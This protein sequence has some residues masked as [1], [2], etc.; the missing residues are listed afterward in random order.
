M[1]EKESW[2]TTHKHIRNFAYAGVCL[3][4]VLT[5]VFTFGR[6]TVKGWI[7]GAARSAGYEITAIVESPEEEN[8][9]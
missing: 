1:T 4:V 9:P 2:L 6:E 3:A 7:E 5:L 8:T